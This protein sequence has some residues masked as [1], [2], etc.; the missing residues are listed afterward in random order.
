[1]ADIPFLLPDVLATG[2]S[3]VDQIVLSLENAG[4]DPELKAAI[5]A[6]S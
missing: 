5:A 4:G 1:M 2:E 6:R 3:A